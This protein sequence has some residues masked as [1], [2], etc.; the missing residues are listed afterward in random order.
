MQLKSGC[1][2]EESITRGF[3]FVKQAGENGRFLLIMTPHACRREGGGGYCLNELAKAQEHKLKILAAM[4]QRV[5]PVVWFPLCGSR[6][7]VPVVW[8]PLWH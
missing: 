2:W 1:D 5:V 4:V 6:C 8:F 7:V 3:E